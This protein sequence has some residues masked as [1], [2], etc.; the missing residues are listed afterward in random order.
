MLGTLGHFR[1]LDEGVL[2]GRLRRGGGDGLE[3]ERVIRKCMRSSG[4]SWIVMMRLGRSSRWPADCL[5]PHL[6]GERGAR[7]SMPSC[8]EASIRLL[9]PPHQCCNRN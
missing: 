4:Q 1:A 9:K 2:H 5:V 6:G 7:P 3:S 8:P